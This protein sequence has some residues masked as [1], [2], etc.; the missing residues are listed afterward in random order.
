MLTFLIIYLFKRLIFC[1]DCL[2]LNALN[3][4]TKLSSRTVWWELPHLILAKRVSLSRLFLVTAP[5]VQRL[6]V[7]L[8][9]PVQFLYNAQLLS[10]VASNSH[11]HKT[12]ALLGEE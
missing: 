3:L 7:F 10:P 5:L 4:R 1:T 8:L 6:R 9:S 12:R 2:A 11:P